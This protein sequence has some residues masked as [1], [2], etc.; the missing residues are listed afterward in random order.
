M[1]VRLATL[2]WLA[3]LRAARSRRALLIALRGHVEN[4]DSLHAFVKSN[5]SLHALFEY[6]DSSRFSS[7]VKYEFE[8]KIMSHH[9]LFWKIMTHDDSLFGFAAQQDQIVFATLYACALFRNVVCH[10]A[11]YLDS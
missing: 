4:N 2:L 8:C 1:A 11:F 5:D 7:L 6:N 9:M 3:L 10:V